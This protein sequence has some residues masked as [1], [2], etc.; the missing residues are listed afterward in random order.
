MRI[1]YEWLKE[2]IDVPE[3]PEELVGEFIRTGTEVDH[4]EKTGAHLDH[5]V[6]GLVLTK[7][8]HSDSDH[9]SVCMED[10]GMYHTDE[11]G[12]P[13]PLQIVCG[14]Q[15]FEAGDKVVVA[16][17]GAVLPGDFKIKKAKK[18][19][20]DSC[21]MN[22]STRELGLGDEHDGI[23]ILPKDAPVGVPFGEYA[24]LSDTVLDCEIT[25][26]RPDCLSM[27]GIAREVGAIYNKPMHADLPQITHEVPV[28]SN[29]VVDVTIDDSSRCSR[30]V[31]RVVRNVK[32]APSPEWLCRR[33]IAAGA[34]PI[35][36]VVDITNY[37]MFLT[38][39]PLH[40]FDFD[41]LSDAGATESQC[42]CSC[43][44]NAEQQDKRH[45]VVRAAHEGEKL[46][47]LDGIERNLT[48]DMTVIT[49]N[50]HTPIALA[51]VMGGANSDIDE[52][53]TTILLESACFDAGHTS[54]TSRSLNLISEAS[55]R[56]ERQVDAAFCGAAADIAA[57]L[58]EEICGAEVLQGC[59]DVYPEPVETADIVLRFD[60]VRALI[61]ATIEND[62]MRD[63]LTALGCD[64]VEEFDGDGIQVHV[65][66]PTNR[67]DLTRE[68]DLVEEI[69]RLWGMDRV[70]PTLPAAR[71]HAGGLTTDQRRERTVGG[72]LRA[73]GLCETST[74]CFADPQDLVRLGLESDALG[75]PV[76][77]INPLVAD[78]SEMR[79]SMLPGLLHAVSYNQAHGVSDI[80]L[81]EIG[82][83]F[84]GHAHKS[85]PQEPLYAAGVI[86]GNRCD[87]T[88]NTAERAADFFDAKGIVEEVL[89]ALCITKV[90]FKVADGTTYPWLQPGQ[91]AEV[92][93]QNRTL[94]WVG[95]I[96]PNV[97]A[98]Y[99]I[100]G[101][102]FAF[103]L[104]MKDLLA[105]AQNQLPYKDV[106]TLPGVDVD[107]ALVVDES[108]TAEQ[109]MQ[110]LTSAGGK[111]LA[112]AVLFDVYR[113]PVR[114]G[115]G[116]K[117]M[118]YALT[119]RAA[120]HTLSSEE[121]EAAHAKL[122]RK[123]C[124]G[125]GAEVRG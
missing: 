79:R 45:I 43:A 12:N 99:D 119:Y 67:P 100:D 77:I 97:C 87:K 83:I 21:G 104:S 25:P 13:V 60:R 117:S 24:Q 15:N 70:V 94:G 51:G 88:W 1:S 96:H 28:C 86:A 105:L 62:E 27:L 63:M 109:I 93:A 115:E 16:L 98:A 113:D 120:D 42:G 59:V 64:I 41:K 8:P 52:T 29:Q 125:L 66:A 69:V 78:E 116:K 121:V 61:G 5:V 3:N 46:T 53:T 33:V 72:V 4:I 10:V 91:A 124:G 32:V 44:P 110:R 80:A 71:N 19:G 36:N 107:L 92:I 31:A 47:T 38:G 57:V 54:R 7:E 106:P 34:R 82:R 58:F 20:I 114:V 89:H 65:I 9:M 84:I 56:Y 30:Y 108:V 6:T 37:V 48:C 90:R 122:V 35:N 14:A 2:L 73:C 81:Y 50:G 101:A 76:E 95:A 112:S 123:V 75:V 18:R 40:A 85:L 39:Q 68:I 17:E 55:M 102:V 74:Y 22:C 118:A 26:N 11:Q 23:I 103:C 49:D 111:L